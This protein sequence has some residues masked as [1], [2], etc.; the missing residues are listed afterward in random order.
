MS[1]YLLKDEDLDNLR[2]VSVTLGALIDAR[3]RHHFL[4]RREVAEVLTTMKYNVDEVLAAA[5]HHKVT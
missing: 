5:R 2:D 4:I 1:H 3:E